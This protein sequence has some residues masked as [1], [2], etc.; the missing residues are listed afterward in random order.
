M[1]LKI[2]TICCEAIR[3]ACPL[4][5]S[6]KPKSCRNVICCK[7][8]APQDGSHW[9]WTSLVLSLQAPWALFTAL[10]EGHCGKASESSGGCLCPPTFSFH[11]QHSTKNWNQ[12]GC[13]KRVYKPKKTASSIHLFIFSLSGRTGPCGTLNRERSPP[14]CPPLGQCN[15]VQYPPPL[16][17]EG[18]CRCATGQRQLLMKGAIISAPVLLLAH[19]C[20]K[21]WLDVG[22]QYSFLH[23]PEW[24]ATKKRQ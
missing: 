5:H 21:Q 23:C 4:Q 20:S 3:L 24:R 1:Y 15:C 9:P 16:Q 8:P 2:F 18:E 19:L 14:A 13:L 22:S 10:P 11:G 12:Q 7:G 6:H 17:P